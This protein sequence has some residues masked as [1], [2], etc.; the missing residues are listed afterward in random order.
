MKNGFKRIRNRSDFIQFSSKKHRILISI[1]F[2]SINQHWY[3]EIIG[4]QNTIIERKV[5][6]TKTQALNFSKEYINKL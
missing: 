5:T 6:P 1:T 4:P 3:V 2:N